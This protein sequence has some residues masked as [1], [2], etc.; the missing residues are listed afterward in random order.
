[1]EEEGQGVVELAHNRTAKVFIT[2]TRARNLPN[3]RSLRI[4]KVMKA[5]FV[6]LPPFARFRAEKPK[7]WRCN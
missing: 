4:G 2:Q 6:E 7:G 1:M 3:I 5:L